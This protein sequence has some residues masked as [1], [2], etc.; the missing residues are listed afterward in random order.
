[1]LTRFSLLQFEKIQRWA[2]K[3][4][5]RWQRRRCCRRCCRRR[6]RCRR[7]CRCRRCLCDVCSAKTNFDGDLA[8][9]LQQQIW[10][11]NVFFPL[12]LIAKP[13]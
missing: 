7:R 3:R 12:F 4:R 1:M 6:R 11:L 10:P 2:L 8:T 5:R 9:T 13:T